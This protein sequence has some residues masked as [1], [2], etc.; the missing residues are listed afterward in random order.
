MYCPPGFNGMTALCLLH[1]LIIGFSY[2]DG[3][4]VEQ[5]QDGALITVLWILQNDISGNFTYMLCKWTKQQSCASWRA[6]YID[7]RI[8]LG[9]KNVSNQRDAG[10]RLGAG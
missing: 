3:I 5:P 2:Q 8:G 1:M 9:K 10:N 7:Q 4:L 6:L